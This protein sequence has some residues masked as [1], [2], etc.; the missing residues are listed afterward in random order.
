MTFHDC[1]MA[2]AGN[3]DFVKEFDRLHGSNLGLRGSGLELAIDE[4]TGRRDNDDF[5][6]FVYECIWLRLPPEARQ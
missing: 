3:G 6:N 5:I 2:C 4:A 1:L